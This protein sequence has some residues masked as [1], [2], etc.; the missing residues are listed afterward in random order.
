VWMTK[1]M[2]VKRQY[3]DDFHFKCVARN[4]PFFGW[5]GNSEKML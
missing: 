1:V 5:F 3:R 2:K 4:S